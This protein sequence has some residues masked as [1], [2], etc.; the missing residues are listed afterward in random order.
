MD[1]LS[2]GA[3]YVLGRKDKGGK[4]PDTVIYTDSD[5]GYRMPDPAQNETFDTFTE[6]WESESLE[7]TVR[8]VWG[9][10]VVNKGKENER[11]TRLVYPD[12]TFVTLVNF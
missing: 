7:K 8:R 6:V 11:V 3:G 5:T 9:V 10:G 2:F 4:H 12:K 1:I